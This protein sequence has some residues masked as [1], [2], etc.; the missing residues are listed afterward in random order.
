MRKSY[1][2]VKVFP[3]Q[4]LRMGGFEACI[5]FHGQAFPVAYY[6]SSHLLLHYLKEEPTIG[7][8][9]REKAYKRREY[10]GHNSQ[11]SARLENAVRTLLKRIEWAIED[12]EADEAA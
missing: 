4:N 5:D 10:L 6:E 3:R 12:M 7:A 2:N 1:D 9:K 8:M 11:A